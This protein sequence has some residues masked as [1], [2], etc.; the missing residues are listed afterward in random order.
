MPLWRNSAVQNLLMYDTFSGTAIFWP[1][2]SPSDWMGESLGTTI[3]HWPS[4]LAVATYW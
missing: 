1:L 4:G 2:S 3:R